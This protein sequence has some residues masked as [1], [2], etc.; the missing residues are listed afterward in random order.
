MNETNLQWHIA[1]NYQQF[2]RTV[3]DKELML[4]V[5]CIP[6]KGWMWSAYQLTSIDERKPDVYKF[7]SESDLFDSFQSA[8][9]NSLEWIE[10]YECPVT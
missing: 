3:D 1:Y 9:M 8:S 4:Y 10:N 6:A 5:N 7:I 2:H